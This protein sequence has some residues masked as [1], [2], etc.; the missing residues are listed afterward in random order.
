MSKKPTTGLS[1]M[2]SQ[3]KDMAELGEFAQAQHKT[4]VDLS[5]KIQE[6][7][8]ENSHLRELMQHKAAVITPLSLDIEISNEEL[9]ALEQLK[10][11]KER[12]STRE[13]T[14]EET[15][16]VEIYTKI[17]DQVRAKKDFKSTPALTNL[18]TKDLLEIVKN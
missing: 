9:I 15:R 13:L 8:K 16:K 3:Y 7:E 17:I 14:L 5:K 18:D 12:S 10:L 6:L 2:F 11:L 4:I 1:E